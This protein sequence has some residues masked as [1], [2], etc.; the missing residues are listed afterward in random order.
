MSLHMRGLLRV[1]PEGIHVWLPQYS[2][3][4]LDTDTL[5][6]RTGTQGARADGV[7]VEEQ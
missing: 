2:P 1:C 3:C 5:N 6:G 7:I 4:T